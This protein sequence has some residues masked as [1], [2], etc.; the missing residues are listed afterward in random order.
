[1]TDPE[2]LGA[3]IAR[4]REASGLSLRALGEAIGGLSPQ[5]MHDVENN[6][7]RIAPEHWVALCKVLPS[8]DL[9]AMAEASLASGPVEIDARTLTADQ[10][11]VLASALVKAAKEAQTQAG[12]KGGRK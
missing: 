3:M 9:M 8:L 11:R 4:A 1:V 12:K 10:R 7:R 5:F 2:T 6:R